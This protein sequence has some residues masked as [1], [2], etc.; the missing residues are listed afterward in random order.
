MEVV[1]MYVRTMYR[2]MGCIYKWDYSV[3]GESKGITII[4]INNINLLT[5]LDEYHALASGQKID[6]DK[7]FVNKTEKYLK[8]QGK[9]DE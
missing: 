9:T 5:L 2:N 6:V 7:K 3:C 1:Y 4:E 8:E